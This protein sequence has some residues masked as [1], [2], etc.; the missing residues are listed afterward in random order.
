MYGETRKP[1][2][3]AGTGLD[4]VLLC[5]VR[6][7]GVLNC[8]TRNATHPL[9]LRILLGFG[10]DLEERGEEGVTSLIHA[11]RTNKASFAMLLS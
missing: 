10:A 1:L 6:V 8:G 4:S 3:K 2:L 9:N 7:D 11:T 5:G